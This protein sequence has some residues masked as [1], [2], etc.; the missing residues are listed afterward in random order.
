MRVLSLL[1]RSVIYLA[2]APVACGIRFCYTAGLLP[3][4]FTRNANSS[5][6]KSFN[7]LGCVAILKKRFAHCRSPTERSKATSSERC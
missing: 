6:V 2:I 5:F 4:N 1:C 3:S 7:Q